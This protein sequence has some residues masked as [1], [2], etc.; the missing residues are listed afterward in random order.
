MKESLKITKRVKYLF[1]VVAMMILIFTSCSNKSEKVVE[2]YCNLLENGNYE[3]VVSII[4]FPENEFVTDDKVEQF[5]KAYAKRMFEKYSDIL[6]CTNE[7]V[8]ETD[9]KITYLLTI[10]T[11]TETEKMNIDVRKKE[12]KIVIDGVFKEQYLTVFKNTK[13]TV[14]GKEISVVPE[15]YINEYGDHVETYIFNFLTDVNY[16]IQVE[17]PIY[18]Y[19]LTILGKYGEMYRIEYNPN[20]D[21]SGKNINHYDYTD[22]ANCEIK[23]ELYSKL[24]ETLTY[25]YT[26]GIKNENVDVLDEYFVN[27]NAKE[28]LEENEFVKRMIQKTEAQEYK[29]TF[30]K[31][32]GVTIDDIVYINENEMIVKAS[33]YCVKDKSLKNGKKIRYDGQWVDSYEQGFQ[34]NSCSYWE[35]IGNEWKIITLQYEE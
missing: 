12:G 18:E 27:K 26:E 17:H 31:M 3:D 10:E 35:K 1:G 4:Y 14:D 8:S 15:E 34:D 11:P 13:V 2:E 25:V 23:E 5:K 16:D 29:Y 21:Y 19:D 28:V 6:S 32:S 9:E 30:K 7:V 20:H 22:F 33:M 24:V